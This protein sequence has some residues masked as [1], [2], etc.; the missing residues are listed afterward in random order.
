MGKVHNKVTVTKYR[1]I[2]KEA[3]AVGL[4]RARPPRHARRAKRGPQTFTFTLEKIGSVVQH[5]RWCFPSDVIPNPV[6]ES[7]SIDLVLSC[8][9][10]VFLLLQG[11][12][13]TL[14]DDYQQNAVAKM[15]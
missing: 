14:E 6:P 5:R 1:E 2:Y 8:T 3:D 9:E 7:S 4:G 15:Y 10:E 13:T 11:K 12:S